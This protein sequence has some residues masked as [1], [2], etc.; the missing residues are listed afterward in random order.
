MEHKTCTSL[1]KGYAR[2]EKGERENF[3]ESER[4]LRSLRRKESPNEHIIIR[5]VHLELLDC[6]M[7]TQSDMMKKI[8]VKEMRERKRVE[9]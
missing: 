4:V 7:G 1:H 5:H 2:S 9:A 3:Y 6:A 8:G